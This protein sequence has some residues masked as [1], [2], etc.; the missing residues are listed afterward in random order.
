MN[1][2]PDTS[3]LISGRAL[4]LAE[5]LSASPNKATTKSR[6]KGNTKSLGNLGTYYRVKINC[7][8]AI[9]YYFKPLKMAEELEDKNGI[10]INLATSDFF[11]VGT[12]IIPKRLTPH[13]GR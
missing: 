8:Q 5:K 11:I 13:A 9:D 7:P 2:Y 3:I 4:H 1:I 6:K 12:Q 10:S